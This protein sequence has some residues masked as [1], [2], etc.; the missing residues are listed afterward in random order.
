M[1]ND[2]ISHLRKEENEKAKRS[3]SILLHVES[4]YE[5]ANTHHNN[6]LHSAQYKEDHST[7]FAWNFQTVKRMR[8]LSVAGRDLQKHGLFPDIDLKTSDTVIHKNYM[9]KR[10]MMIWFSET[11][12]QYDD[13]GLFVS[14][15]VNQSSKRNDTRL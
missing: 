15:Q 14:G 9:V 11:L 10:Y 6:E 4:Q 2:R 13:P 1:I 7:P 12:E 8:I 3:T 5:V